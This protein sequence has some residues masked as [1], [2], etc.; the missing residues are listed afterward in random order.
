MNEWI[1]VQTKLPKPNEYVL[2]FA[3]PN[4]IQ[5][6]CMS[7]SSLIDWRI[8]VEPRWVAPYQYFFYDNEITHWMP[9]PE[10]PKGD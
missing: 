1:I 10:P 8:K 6:T 3:P 9:L 4:N 5:I 7:D 2:I